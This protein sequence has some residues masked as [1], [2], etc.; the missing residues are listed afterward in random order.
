MNPP[1]EILDK[2]QIE[3]KLLTLPAQVGAFQYE[4]EKKRAEREH[5]E[6][7]LDKRLRLEKEDITATEIKAITLADDVRFNMYLEEIKALSQYTVVNETLMATKR[8]AMIRDQF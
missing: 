2:G 3:E 7:K 8:I 4:Y 1:S 5:Y 6:G